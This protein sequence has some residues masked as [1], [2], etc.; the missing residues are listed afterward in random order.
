MLVFIC[1]GGFL[2]PWK[3]IKLTIEVSLNW[4]ALFGYSLPFMS[5]LI[6]VICA[7]IHGCSIIF[8]LD[9]SV[10]LFTLA[11]YFIFFLTVSSKTFGGIRKYGCLQQV[12]RVHLKIQES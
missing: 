4:E 10:V 5:I 2:V 3:P 7:P 6:F 1:Q 11:S 12:L 8:F 9:F